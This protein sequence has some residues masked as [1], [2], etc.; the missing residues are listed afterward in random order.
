VYSRNAGSDQPL[1]S[2]YGLKFPQ[3][4]IYAA[5]G[6]ADY[7]SYGRTRE[8]W[9]DQWD[10]L[11]SRNRSYLPEPEFE[12]PC[13][14]QYLPREDQTRGPS[15]FTR[16]ELLLRL[17]KQRDAM[18]PSD[19]REYCAENILVGIWRIKVSTLCCWN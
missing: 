11:V 17:N 7:Y 9:Q 8:R 12:A 2:I 3:D 6:V 10:R 18:E 19:I 13:F 4:S 15:T 16:T 14:N 5:G 1:A